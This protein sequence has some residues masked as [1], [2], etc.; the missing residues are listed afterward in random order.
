MILKGYYAL[1]YAN[2]A[3]LL[4]SATFVGGRRWYC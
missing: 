2:L 3:I 4:L 1:C